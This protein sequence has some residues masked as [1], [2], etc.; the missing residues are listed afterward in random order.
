MKPSTPWIYCHDADGVYQASVRGWPLAGAMMAVL[1]N[2]ATVRFGGHG[3]TAIV[4]T[5]GKDGESAES[6]DAVFEHVSELWY[7]EALCTG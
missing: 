7:G 5:E 1:G 3:K 2:G 4:Y 6:Y